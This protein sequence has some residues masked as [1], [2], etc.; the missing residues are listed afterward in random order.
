MNIFESTFEKHKKLM[1][2][3]QFTPAEYNRLSTDVSNRMS[4]VDKELEKAETPELLKKK[5]ELQAYMAKLSDKNPE[6]QLKQLPNLSQNQYKQ[7]ST[8]LTKLMA[9]D[10][11]SFVTGLSSAI[12]DLKVQK[13]LMMA[14]EDGTSDDDKIS[15]QEAEVNVSSLFPTQNE[16][17]LEK[18][19]DYPIKTKPKNI[20]S[21]IKNGIGSMP[22]IV[23]SGNYII[24]GHHRWSQIYCLNKNGKIPTYNISFDGKEDPTT[25]LKKIHIGIAATTG[26]VPLTGGESK[27]TN[28]FTVEY[29]VFRLWI[30]DRLSA[31]PRA[32]DAFKQV[33]DEMRKKIGSKK[34]VTTEMAAQ[35][36][37]PFIKN[38]ILPYLWSNVE[39]I[40][41]NRGKY[42]RSI[43]PQT[44]KDTDIGTF[45]NTIKSGDINVD[46]QTE[47]LFESTFNKFKNLYT[48]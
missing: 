38:V 22:S 30:T 11:P 9:G 29:N 13:F 24:D 43:M 14:R 21:Y 4:A 28:L 34:D 41:A 10:L 39:A 2:E 45:I 25:I 46:V 18:S 8:N 27:D 44:E 26:K 3:K 17:F 5:Q 15:V 35:S 48:K 31:N 6:K 23:V 20:S 36:E 16:V 47:N 33:E 7:I 12:K 40:K 19:L 42:P 1:L 32:L 37:D